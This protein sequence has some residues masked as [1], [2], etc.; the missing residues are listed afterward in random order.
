MRGSAINWLNKYPCCFQTFH[1]ST[2]ET[3][4][5]LFGFTKQTE[6]LV[7]GEEAAIEVSEPEMVNRLGKLLMLSKDRRLNVSKLKGLQR[8]F[9]FPN[10]F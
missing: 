7:A 4:D 10:L 6:E 9:G 1:D 3:E 5:L 8:S 2:G